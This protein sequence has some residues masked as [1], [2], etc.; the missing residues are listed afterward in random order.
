MLSQ[1]N[2][3][4]ADR[5]INIL[6][7]SLQ[8]NQEIGYVVFDIEKGEYKNLLNELYNIEGTIRAGFLY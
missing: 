7:Q 5:N 6:S 3:I 4:F 8:T 1:V 2:K